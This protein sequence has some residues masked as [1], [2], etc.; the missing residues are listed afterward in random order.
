MRRGAFLLLAGVLALAPLAAAAQSPELRA[1]HS[2][3]K[4]LHATGHNAE[5]AVTAGEALALGI[6]EFGE[7]HPSTAALMTTLAELRALLGEW[8]EAERLFRR[9]AAVREKTL[10][11]THPDTGLARAGL[12]EALGRQERFEEAEASYWGAL[13]SL[14]VEVARNVHV[15]DEISVRA[16][17]YRAWALYYRAQRFAAAGR[18]DEAEPL[19]HSA[20]TVFEANGSVDRATI[21]AALG[22]R[23]A[24]LRALGRGGEADEIDAHADA[25]SKG[26][27]SCPAGLFT[28]C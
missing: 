12:G 19:Y 21:V 11:A 25:V 13:H 9:A 10:G 18:F 4:R 15:F 24:V 20:I 3:V 26:R 16:G 6:D 8:P 28:F 27:A 5:A 22:K 17:L 1:K 23:A 7:E 14:G 2:W